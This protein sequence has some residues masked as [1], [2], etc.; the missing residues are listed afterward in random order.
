MG[1][2]KKVQRQIR[3]NFFSDTGEQIRQ[4]HRWTVS[5]LNELREIKKIKQRM[6]EQFAPVNDINVNY[7]SLIPK[8]KGIY[9]EIFSFSTDTDKILNKAKIYASPNFKRDRNLVERSEV[10]LE[11]YVKSLCK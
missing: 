6:F 3:Y 11:N 10:G 5:I 2:I 8:T 7:L 1:R 9:C 4:R